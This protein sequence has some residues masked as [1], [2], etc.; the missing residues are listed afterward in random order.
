M[1]RIMPIKA[2]DPIEMIGEIGEQPGGPGKV[3]VSDTGR[4][5]ERSWLKFVVEF[6]LLG[7]RSKVNRCR[8]AGGSNK[9]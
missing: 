5:H 8:W 2:S 7:E 3:G 6:V 4:V 1:V 9:K